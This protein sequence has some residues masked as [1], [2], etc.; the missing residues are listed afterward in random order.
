VSDVPEADL[1]RYA[2]VV[3]DV[4]VEVEPDDLVLINAEVEYARFARI[5]AERAYARGARYVDIWYFDPYARLSRLRYAEQ[6]TLAEVPAW[7]DDR[8]HELARRH[9]V[10][11]N[12]RGQE[13]LDPLDGIDPVRAGLDR[14][15]ALA[16]RIRLQV[17]QLARWTI[18]PYPTPEWAE[19]VFGAP[20]TARLW[21]HLRGFLRL[22][23]PDPVAAWRDRFD[24]LNERAAQLTELRLDA[25]HFEG[26]GTD[27]TI[28]L[29]PDTRWASAELESVDGRVFQACL[30]T[31]EVY[32][33]PD[34]HRVD[35]VVRSTRPLALAGTVVED[36]ELTFA[37]GA[38]TEVR[39]TKGADVVR[40][41]QATDAGSN[42]LGEVALVDGSSPIGR[43]GRTFTHTLIDENAVC[44]LAWGQG[45][46]SAIPDARERGA[47]GLEALGVN[48]SSVHI[49]FMV[50]NPDVT[51]TGIR[52]DGTRIPLLRDHAWQ[53]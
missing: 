28:G 39:A 9:G 10:L 40:A 11:I 6:A 47:K 36:L 35:G 21:E 16:S 20:D 7:V 2:E 48:A 41:H 34:R 50:G 18:V 15:P 30:P 45:L 25:V 53:F 32:T 19:V 38:V 12:I 31:E 8:H 43:S 13:G 42:R 1:L 5:L 44:H 27:L 14:M 37:G 52:P 23:R 17:E 24:A 51:V 4:A 46:W 49:D 26:P 29:I 22:D 3:V 33:T